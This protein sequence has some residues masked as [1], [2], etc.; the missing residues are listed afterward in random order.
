ML[1][2][3][4]GLIRGGEY[5]IVETSIISILSIVNI[6]SGSSGGTELAF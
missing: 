3:K 6:I 1:F 2:C 4:N 5:G